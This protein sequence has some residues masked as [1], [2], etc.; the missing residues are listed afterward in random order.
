MK[1]DERQTDERFWSKVKKTE[2][3]WVWTGYLSDGYGTFEGNRAHRV[4]FFLT[5][6]RLTKGLLICHRCDNRACVR[7]DHLFEGTYSDNSKDAYY[8]GRLNP[9]TNNQF[10]KDNKIRVCGPILMCD[11]V[12]IRRL[13]NEGMRQ[14]DIAK[15]FNQ[16]RN[17]IW[18]IVR[19]KSYSLME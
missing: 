8:K 12:E 14:V 15:L 2:L 11:V 10:K 16:K 7:P 1:N 6:K 18:K 9:P 19:G 5:Y 17:T 4:A 3:C 13:F